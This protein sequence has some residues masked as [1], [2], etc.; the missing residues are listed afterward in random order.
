MPGTRPGMLPRE[1]R[2]RASCRILLDQ[3][4]PRRQR[5]AV[6]RARAAQELAGLGPLQPEV[7]VVLPRVPDAAVELQ[8]VLGDQRLALAGGDLRDVRRLGRYRIVLGQR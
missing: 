3:P 8:T 4:E 2:S 6:L 7:E 5:G 1:G